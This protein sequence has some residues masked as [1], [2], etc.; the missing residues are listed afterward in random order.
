ME[1]DE[2]EGKEEEEEEQGR[3]AA[4]GGRGAGGDRARQAE[5]GARGDDG[6]ADLLPADLKAALQSLDEEVDQLFATFASAQQ[7]QQQHPGSDSGGPL[8]S[9]SAAQLRRLG[10]ALEAACE[11]AGAGAAI[12]AAWASGR[13]LLRLLAAALR[14]PVHDW[15]AGNAATDGSA[16]HLRASVTRRTLGPV[17]KLAFDAI[18][19]AG[20]ASRPAQSFLRAAVRTQALHAASRQ[21]AA[22]AEALAPTAGGAA[23][24]AAGADGQAGDKEAVVD[25]A[26]S[27]LDFTFAFLFTHY[28]CLPPA[29]L[30]DPV[31]PSAQ[32]VV[33]ELLEALESSQVLEH[34]ARVLLLVLV[35]L[36]GAANAIMGG[37]GPLLPPISM[38][39]F[40]RF[41]DVHTCFAVLSSNYCRSS[42]AATTRLGLQLRRVLCGRCVTHAALVLGLSA[43]TSADGGSSY[44]LEEIVRAPAVRVVASEYHGDPTAPAAGSDPP[45]PGEDALLVMM[46]Q[47]L[48]SSAA[49]PRPPALPC[50]RGV[51]SIAI[52]V[53]RLDV[54]Y[55]RAAADQA[56]GGGGGPQPPPPLV[57][58]SQNWWTGFLTTAAVGVA[59]LQLYPLDTTGGRSAAVDAG[60]EVELWRLG[61]AALRWAHMRVAESRLRH[62]C[63]ALKDAWRHGEQGNEEAAG[64]GSLRLPP[65]PPRPVA[66]ALSG[67][68]LPCLEYLLRSAGRDPAGGWQALAV[69]ELAALLGAQLPPLLAYGDEREAAALVAT[70]GK[71][72]RRALAAPQVLEGAWEP[73]ANFWQAV[74]CIVS[75]LISDIE[76]PHDPSNDVT[77]PAG[78]APE[79]AGPQEPEAAAAGGV[80]EAVEAPPQPAASPASQQFAS[81]LSFAACH[82]LP[83]LSRL[84]RAALA[85]GPLCADPACGLG[86]D[87]SGGGGS[88]GGGSGG[89]GGSGSGSGGG[90]FS[91]GGI[92]GSHL[93]AASLPWV[94]LLAI[95]CGPQAARRQESDSPEGAGGSD[96][97]DGSGGGGGDGGDGGWRAL[98]LEEAAVGPLLSAAQEQSAGL[99]DAGLSDDPLPPL[100]ELLAR[101]RSHIA[102]LRSAG[103]AAAAPRAARPS[104]G[105]ASVGF[106]RTGAAGS[107]SAALGPF[108]ALEAEIEAAARSSSVVGEAE[109]GGG[110]DGSGGGGGAPPVPEPAV[111]SALR[112]LALAMPPPAAARRLLRTCANPGCANLEGDS[113]AELRLTPCAGC[114]EAAYCCRDCW[115]AH[116]RAGHRAACARRRLEAGGQ[117]GGVGLT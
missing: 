113:E 95:C 88:L 48:A 73:R 19:A 100:A 5:E 54:E 112:R 80:A 84:A 63:T 102:A 4:A 93:L 18:R 117:A 94:P 27:L 36:A 106:E 21:L 22:L 104:T 90:G 6:E 96:E 52:R 38:R 67:G 10:K 66:A 55:K 14:L 13:S 68:L 98:L 87:G 103:T 34:A 57:P 61:V 45:R 15:I 37:G 8:A 50:R 47:L 53:G 31:A 64:G 43:L 62:F 24:G 79:P 29:A 91:G 33:A 1:E 40:G 58:P 114:G 11:P 17:S 51:L 25:V 108:L 49:I 12:L 89:G 92:A 59:A 26:T 85:S 23:G 77:T 28:Y 7:Q 107:S 42:D 46:L 83:S 39:A 82:W 86:G 111:G 105:G 81:L 30:Q 109:D 69:R 72:L 35:A 71:L 32:P 76:G 65:S 70:L 74:L 115:T 16:R 110:K 75:A 3:R 116:W 20:P 2:E 101:C 97:G 41:L 60:A 44:G 78:G 99:L 56:S 9:A